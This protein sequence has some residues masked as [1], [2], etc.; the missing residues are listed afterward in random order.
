MTGCGGVTAAALTLVVEQ[1]VSATSR[2]LTI[3]LL[4]CTALMPC[5]E[6]LAGRPA[7]EDAALTESL[8]SSGSAT[9][10]AAAPWLAGWTLG[11]QVWNLR[12][13]FADT[14]TDRVALVFFA[15]WC[16]PCK[17]G[18]MQLTDRAADL[19][20]GGVSVVLVDYQEDA[21]RVRGFLGDNPA[22]PVVLDRFGASEQ[23]YL[24]TNDEQARLPRTVL[25]GRDM[26]VE[27]IFGSEGGDYVDRLLSGR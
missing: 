5:R 17:Q 24:R 2:L 18:V 20:A 25:I 16:A 19:K 21:A 10:G 3:A 11:D 23:S 6:A 12:K 8:V 27:A 1:Y 9:V 7:V 26:K 13:A 22:F 4:L 15:T 14:S